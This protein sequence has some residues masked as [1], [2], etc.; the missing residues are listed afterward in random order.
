MPKIASYYTN[1]VA[2][3]WCRE[4][5]NGN[6]I[7]N[8]TYHDAVTLA[9]RLQ[10]FDW[11]GDTYGIGSNNMTTNAASNYMYE[12]RN[13]FTLR[14][15]TWGMNWNM[16]YGGCW[17]YVTGYGKAQAAIQDTSMHQRQYYM[18][19]GKSDLNTWTGQL[20]GWGYVL[21]CGANPTHAVQVYDTAIEDARF[22]YS[23][24]T[25]GMPGGF[26]FANTVVAGNALNSNIQAPSFNTIG[27]VY[28]WFYCP[29]ASAGG[30]TGG[31]TTANF[32]NF[33]PNQTSSVAYT[34]I[35]VDTVYGHGGVSTA[36][37]GTSSASRHLQLLTFTPNLVYFIE[38]T[39]SSTAGT[40]TENTTN[41]FFIKKMTYSGTETTVISHPQWMYGL[42]LPTQMIN[43]TANTANVIY[44][45]FNPVTANVSYG[46]LSLLRLDI[47]KVLNSESISLLS[48]TNS[49]GQRMYQV[50]GIQ[51]TVTAISTYNDIYW[52]YHAMARC[53]LH[54][55]IG[56]QNYLNISFENTG[57]SLASYNNNNNLTTLPGTIYAQSAL[58]DNA[59]ITRR[60]EFFRVWTFTIDTN[61]TSAVYQAESDF[62]NV[63]PRWF[64]PLR[65]DG[66]IQYMSSMDGTVTDRVCRFDEPT[67]KWSVVATM[68]YRADQIGIDAQN[69][70]YVSTAYG[71]HPATGHG[72]T[73]LYLDSNVLP[74]TVSITPYANTYTYS[75]ANIST[76]ISVTT[77]NIFGNLVAANVYV[78]LSGGM[79]FNNGTTSA[80][81]AT[82][83]IS[84]VTANT[85]VISTAPINITGTINGYI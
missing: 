72:L 85:I 27:Q 14:G 3:A 23:F 79:I 6:I 32:F 83:N 5:F 28:R 53:W 17:Y 50:A 65:S 41:V 60:N 78:T 18:N 36:T 37:L 67:Y 25:Q 84:A 80:Y 34:P 48:I 39:L 16:P 56:G 66:M 76:N 4:T 55:G 75:G 45:L 15:A 11:S 9:P 49:P 81:I 30:S 52:R 8:G 10:R 33:A 68:P 2:S 44:P 29:H 70:I 71:A 58:N 77:T 42:K 63:Y 21:A 13:Q 24:A 1:T 22:N 73:G 74:Q 69:R 59:Q 35:R 61:Y 64:Y 20:P 19:L 54:T 12:P 46:N 47:S 40:G 31:T 57:Y 62:G 82:S 38:H 51:N 7:L 43:E 26:M